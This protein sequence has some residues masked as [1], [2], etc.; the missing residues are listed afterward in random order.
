MGLDA[1]FTLTDET[2]T[3]GGRTLR[4]VRYADGTLG[5]FVQST[6]NLA[7]GLVL[8]DACVMD[9]SVV[10]DHAVVKGSAVV[11]CGSIVADNAVVLGRAE[12]RSASVL[13]HAS[14]FD[15]AGIYGSAVQGCARVTGRARLVNAF[16]G[17][18]ACILDDASVVDAS[19]LDSVRVEADADVRGV[20][21]DGR[22][23]VSADARIRD[24][25]DVLVLRNNWS[26]GRTLTAYRTADGGIRW[27]V[28]CFRGTS[29]ELAAKAA[30]DP[31]PSGE[32]HAAAIDFAERVFRALDRARGLPDEKKD[33]NEKG[34][35]E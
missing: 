16:A 34:N 10:R 30:R 25:R 27:C 4:R 32:C 22:A 8:D 20:V 24:R 14:V 23:A 1:G 3:V 28:G 17:G 12:L 21:L 9:D 5:G 35:A 26:S 15:D 2:R 31:G 19:L 13:G 6:R 29:A 7:G 18:R 11:S 33:E